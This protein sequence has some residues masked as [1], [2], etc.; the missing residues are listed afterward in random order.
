[1]YAIVRRSCGEDCEAGCTDDVA[2]FFL[3]KSKRLL[4]I[5]LPPLL[6]CR[7]DKNKDNASVLQNINTAFKIQLDD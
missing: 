3:L 5:L 4:F 1:M 2:T 6:L 7:D